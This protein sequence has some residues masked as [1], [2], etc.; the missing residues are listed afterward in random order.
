MRAAGVSKATCASKC[1]SWRWQKAKRLK[2]QSSSAISYRRDTSTSAVARHTTAV[3]KNVKASENSR[4][5]AWP[6]A[7]A[8]LV[9]LGR[10]R[11]ARRE[12]KLARAL[13]ASAAR[14]RLSASARRRSR[15]SGGGAKLKRGSRRE[16]NGDHRRHAEM[17][18]VNGVS[19][20]RRLAAASW[21]VMPA[22]QRRRYAGNQG[23]R[24]RYNSQAR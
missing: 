20:G 22:E 6:Y 14:T 8:R 2:R 11:N 9:A 7:L 3:P 13:E 21:H 4:S 24:R 15:A 10:K 1:A 12:V 5:Y 23:N 18:G 16:K 17:H 19:S